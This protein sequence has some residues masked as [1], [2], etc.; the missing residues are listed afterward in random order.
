MQVQIAVG[1][2]KSRATTAVV[3]LLYLSVALIFGVV[4][5]HHDADSLG[6]RHDCAACAWAIN[7]VAD[8]PQ[9]PVSTFYWVAQSPLQVFKSIL[10]F[11]PAFS[12][13]LSRAPPVAPA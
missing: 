8:A 1:V 7:A 2:M 6:P 3:C 10:D 4:H 11:A 12:F 5:H 9:V 13:S